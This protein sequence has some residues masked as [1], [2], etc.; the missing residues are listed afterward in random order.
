MYNRLII[1]CWWLY[2]GGWKELFYEYSLARL[3]FKNNLISLIKIFHFDFVTKSN[4]IQFD[5]KFYFH[6]LLILKL[7]LIFSFLNLFFINKH[8]TE[9]LRLLTHRNS[10]IFSFLPSNFHLYFL[11]SILL[12]HFAVK[13]DFARD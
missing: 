13:F 7:H 12:D 11:N 6:Q 1:H 10:I 8:L 2:F 5:Q 9:F 4:L 3:N